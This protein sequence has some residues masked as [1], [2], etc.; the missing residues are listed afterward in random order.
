MNRSS[1]VLEP[2]LSEKAYGLEQDSVYV[3]CVEKHLDKL[4]IA[5]AV[6]AQFKVT[7]KTVNTTLYK[8]KPKRTIR[9]GGRTARG[10]TSIFKKAYV[11]LKEGSSIALLSSDEDEKRK[12]S[13][14]KEK[15]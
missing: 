10:H 2:R 5:R 6:E 12:K 1:V 3:F 11:T 15:R 7:V 8:G 9:K 14:K 4:A 13:V